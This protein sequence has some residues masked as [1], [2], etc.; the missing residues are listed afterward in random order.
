MTPSQKEQFDKAQ[1]ERN[2]VRDWLLMLMAQSSVKPA[3]KAQLL[4]IAQSK[5]GVSKKSFEGGWDIAIIE[6]G[7]EHWWKPYPRAGRSAKIVHH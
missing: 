4:A 3:T 2:Q 5:F 6:S 1:S 7:N